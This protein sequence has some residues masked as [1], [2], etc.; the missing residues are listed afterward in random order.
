MCLASAPRSPV[1]LCVDSQ[2]HELRLEVDWN[3][4]VYLKVPQSERRGCAAAA[5]AA[6]FMHIYI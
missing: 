4:K 3:K 6:A 2:D 1:T 5:G